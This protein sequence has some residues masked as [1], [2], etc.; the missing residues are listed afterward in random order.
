MHPLRDFKFCESDIAVIGMSGRFPGARNVEEYWRNLRE[1]KESVTRYTDEELVAAG[2]EES[3]LKDPH[4]VKAGGLLEG[5][6]VFDAEFFGFTPRE[7]EVLD[8][9]QRILLECAWEAIERAGYDPW[10]FAGAIGVY[11]GASLST[12]LLRYL[13][14]NREALESA[15]TLQVLLSN[16]KDFLA[17]RL[18]YKLNLR[19]PSITV[20]TACSTSLVAVHLAC[21]ALL[22]GECDIALAG[23]VSVTDY[24]KGGYHYQPGGLLS[25]DG[26]CRAFDAQATGTVSGNGAGIVVL[27]RLSEAMAEGDQIHAVIRGSA[28]NN[29]GALKVGYSAPRIEGEAQAVRNAHIVA[30]VRAETIGYVEAHGSGTELGDPIEVAALNEAFGDCGGRRQFCAIGSVKTNVGHLDV[31]AGVAGL[32]KAV[33]AVREGEI[34]ASLHFEQ[35]NPKIDFKQGPFYVNT[36]LRRWEPEQR[37]RA[38]VSSFG[39]GGTNA[40]VVLE[41]APER[42]REGESDRPG[43]ELLVLSARS[44]NA[45]AQGRQRLLQHLK[46]HP[47]R[48]ADVAWTL[49]VGRREF[50]YREAV[51]CRNLQQVVRALEGDDP[52]A[53]IS[54]QAAEISRTVTFLLPGVG[55]QYVGMGEGLYEMENRY[56]EEL[57]RCCE[58]FRKETGEGVLGE[59]YRKQPREAKSGQLLHWVK[60]GKKEIGRLQETVMEQAA[61]FAMDYALAQMWMEWGVRP[62]CVLGYSLGEYVAACLAGVM[63]VEEAVRVV[64]SRARLMEK[65]SRGAMVAVGL[66]V[67]EVQRYLEG[68]LEVAIDSATGVS[69]VGGPEEEIEGLQRRL[70]EAGVVWRRQSGGC[71]MHTRMMKDAGKKLEEVMR[72]V[73]LREPQLE[74]ISNVNGRRVRSGELTE[75]GYWGR[76]VWQRVRFREGLQEVLSTE[77]ATLLEAGPGQSLSSFAQQTAAAEGKEVLVAGSVRNQYEECGDEEYVR[78]SIGKLWSNGVRVE[79]K[80]MVKGEK[81]RRVEL[82]TY[83]FERKRYWAGGEAKK[84]R[85]W[86][87]ER[88]A[89]SERWLYVPT[90]RRTGQVQPALEEGPLAQ[91]LI[92][93]ND[94]PFCRA[95]INGIN[96]GKAT[97]IVV[98]K[99]E[100]YREV[101]VDHFTLAP[102]SRPDYSRLFSAL[103]GWGRLPDKVLYLWNLGDFPEPATE[104]VG[105]FF[106]LFFLA[107]A[108]GEINFSREVGLFV[109]SDQTEKIEKTDV[110]CPE[111]SLLK[112]PC[113]VL[114]QEY[115]NLKC[116]HI[117]IDSPAQDPKAAAEMAARLLREIRSQATEEFIGLRGQYRWAPGFAPIRPEQKRGEALLRS[118]G[119]YLITGGLGG[120]GLTLAGYL[121][122]TVRA[123]LVLIGWRGLPP[124]SEWGQWVRE[125]GEGEETSQRIIR[126]RELEE[127]GA[128]VLVLEADVANREQMQEAVSTAHTRFGRI[129]GVIHAAG[130]A[131]GG[132]LQV[133]EAVEKVFCPKVQGTRVVV[134]VVESDKPDFIVLCSSLGSLLGGIG[135]ADYYA[136]NAY[137]DA[138]AQQAW[139]R[140]ERITAVNWDVWQEVGMALRTSVTGVLS[141]LRDE[142]IRQGIRPAEG[143]EVFVRIVGSGEGQVIVSTQDLEARLEWQRKTGAAGL[144]QQLEQLEF[145]SERKGREGLS[146]EWAGARNEVEER[147]TEVWERVLGIKGIGIHDNFFELGGNSLMGIQLLSRLRDALGVALPLSSLFSSPTIAGLAEFLQTTN[148]LVHLPD[149]IKALDKIKSAHARREEEILQTVRQMSEAEIERALEELE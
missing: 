107:Q 105:I 103:R 52:G 94:T 34:P 90:W 87:F 3:I 132:M 125:H 13:F 124:R 91:W 74:Y 148:Q 133:R 59:M 136:A 140:G 104:G 130:V 28:V 120:I 15:G 110:L 47:E 51:I 108:L 1:G 147:V 37:R 35:P 53:V 33:L 101:D 44:G 75:A 146:S 24:E 119:V 112:G 60:G 38:G 55:D 89:D 70:S 29:D 8:P 85:Q 5:A 40:H 45:L 126:V 31:A 18:S 7:A 117:D 82:P 25:A 50:K 64:A 79:W 131:G 149:K 84:G 102:D 56:R 57:E 92:F 106:S 46:E 54:G 41:E 145:K 72:G 113:R 65:G 58:L 141:Q 17:T 71:A 19:G 4:Y 6:D 135:Q 76:H 95:I 139:E 115:V 48:L 129:N 109:V 23:G 144:R 67:Q 88:L 9:Q 80:K 12:Y 111:K 118:Q 32:I 43:V 61:V 128:E 98:S 96:E 69:V 121:A 2:V 122:R 127:A 26:K 68:R 116:R 99:G 78:R 14:P 39:I 138:Y 137:Q 66:G 27:K 93:A 36:Q 143:A 62:K 77:G 73:K 63:S 42:A 83:A 16:D 11:V 22:G 100:S 86:N 114:P 134:S 142:W 20:Q 81:R 49:Q 21:Q 10:Q 97:A 30:R 123:K